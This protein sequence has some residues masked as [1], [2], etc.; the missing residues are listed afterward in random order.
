MRQERQAIRLA[1]F[2]GL[3]L[4]HILINT[5][6]H[7]LLPKL[8]HANVCWQI[9]GTAVIV[10]TISIAS[11]STPPPANPLTKF[12]DRT[13]LKDTLISSA[14]SSSNLSSSLASSISAVY[15][16]AIGLLQAQYTYTGLDAAVH[17]CGEMLNASKGGPIGIIMS[18]GVASIVGLTYILGLAFAIQ[19]Y[20]VKDGASGLFNSA[21]GSEVGGNC[22]MGIVMVAMFFAGLFA[23]TT[24]SRILYTFA[25]DGGLPRS[26]YWHTLSPHTHMPTRTI[27]L[28]AAI[29]FLITTPSLFS[30]TAF[31]AVTSIAT[32]G[33]FISYA[34]PIVLRHTLARSWFWNPSLY[35]A[36][37][38]GQRASKV[39]G[40]ISIMWVGFVSI[41]FILPTRFP[42]S[43]DNF[44]FA[45]VMVVIAMGGSLGSWWFGGV[46]VWFKGPRQCNL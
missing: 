35:T 16:A 25:G 39:V 28:T 5:R 14:S 34:I 11:A 33:L 2:F 8:N 31:T 10:V 19:D 30:I 40:W 17:S 45:A 18:V 13:G 1:L 22:L 23:I 7:K 3:H 32:I 27:W 42:V 36:S 37:F 29:A 44:N 43:I 38:L 24:T 41:L 6:G 9:L 4:L 12:I 26:P 15:A 46:K 21:L 20:P